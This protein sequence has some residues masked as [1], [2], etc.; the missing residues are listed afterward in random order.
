MKKILVFFAAIVLIFAL[1][2]CG[3]SEDS[4]NSSSEDTSTTAEE[5]VAVEE[6]E[7]EPVDEFSTWDREQQNAYKAAL[8]YL[9]FAPFSKQGLIDQLSSEY[10]DNYP[11]DVAEFAVNKIEERGEVDWVEQAKIAAENYLDLSS[12]SKEGLI[13]Q[14][15]SEYGDQYT[16]E[17]AEAAVEAVY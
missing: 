12:F 8:N 10:G 9:D 16:R 5:S 14:L 2:A 4:D 1:M 6:E 17:Q 7:E 11:Q 15:C 13:E 3:G